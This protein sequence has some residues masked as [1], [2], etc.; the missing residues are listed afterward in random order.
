MA[1]PKDLKNSTE[2]TK[3]LNSTLEDAKET[4]DE[5]LF[6]SRDFSN[7]VAKAAKA[8]F[9]NSVQASE[10]TKSFKTLA[11][12]SR[13]FA[14][15][16]SDVVDG[17][18]SISDLNKLLVK[19][20]EAKKKFNVEYRQALSQAGI[21]QEKIKSIVEDQLSIYD[22][23]NDEIDNLTENQLELLNYYEEQNVVLNDQEK[24]LGQIKNKA[25]Q[26][27][28][29][30]GGAGKTAEGLE[31]ILNKI[32]ASKLTERLGIS[33]AITKSRQFAANLTKGQEGPLSMGQK[34]GNQ[35]KVLG[36][37]A[38]NV[39]GNLVKSLGPIPLIIG[40]VVKAIQFFVE[41]AFESNKRIV[42]LSRNLQISFKQAEGID[43]YFKGIKN[44]LETQYK[45]TKEIYQAQAEL[46][47][48]SAASNLYSKE[49]LDAQIQL[50]KEYGLQAQ[51]AAN[52]NKFFM[53]GNKTST[54]NLDIAAETTAQF[55]K[56]NGILFNE[57]K[58]LEQAS[59][60]SGQLLVS[61]KGSTAE[62]IKSV[63]QA[64]KLGITLDQ[65]KNISESMLNF[66]ESIS[67]ELEAELL[68][69]KDLN[70][71][72]ARALSLQGKFSEAAEEALKNVG[73]LAE[74]QEMNVIQ[75]QALAKAAGLTVDQLSDSLIQQ[76]LITDVQKSQYQ[77][78]KDAGEDELARRFALN[79][80]TK[81]EVLEANKRL[82]AQQNFNIAVEQ[83]KEIFSDLVTGGTLQDLSETLKGAVDFLADFLGMTEKL[84]KKRLEKAGYTVEESDGL[85]GTGAFKESILK[86]DGEEIGYAIGS[87][88][89]KALS[90]EYLPKPVEKTDDF[91]IRPGQPTQK[92]NKDD[93]IIG[94]TNL[95]GNNNNNSN[96]EVI[97]L[98]KEL[99]STTKSGNEIYIDSQKVTG[100]LK[101]SSYK[102]DYGVS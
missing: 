27:D 70:L 18:K 99:I 85:F 36:N 93:L 94:G 84:E 2:E 57:R 51:D 41:A 29:A 23:L 38:G 100:A 97:S 4:F 53:I 55:F 12:L 54:E 8:V 13:D 49:T 46:S 1:D 34:I 59:K 44:S 63:A 48:L 62:L 102:A 32:G 79:D 91:I 26:I 40:A 50:T 37:L 86:K 52:L 73:S 98:L 42:D 35:F 88:G 101:I 24:V 92:F 39:G 17:T 65:A 33:D 82:D 71:D 31:A 14:S 72:R 22:A 6:A 68:T 11:S 20:E 89:I 28:D 64:N 76:K 69:G 3:K 61:F 7:E 47:E 67:S 45:L 95:M 90:E 58:L 19:Q 74:F 66:E 9:Q 83:A 81:E 10:Q 16:I 56:Q 43:A 87:R 78:F 77:R 21:S 60:V 75:Q 30:F 15:Q 25:D 5:L 96:N 80:I